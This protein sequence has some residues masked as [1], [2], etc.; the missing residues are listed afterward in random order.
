[1]AKIRV[2]LV[3][4]HAV[5]RAGVRML[6]N[7]Q[8]D[9]EVCGEAA[10]AVEAIT[11]TE[12]TQPDVVT[13]DL[14]MPGGSGLKMIE[15]LRLAGPKSRILVLTMHDDPAY[16][17]AA[18]AAGCTGYVVKTAADAALLTAIRAV[19]RGRT[20]VDMALTEGGLL[21]A[22][23]KPG[24][25]GSTLSEREREVFQLLVQGHTNQA[26]ADKLNLSVKTVETYRARIGDKLGLKSRADMVRYAMETGMLDQPG[27]SGT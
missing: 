12:E 23:T 17:R 10:S 1:M 9:M 18:L 19:H 4:D 3:D 6:I 27:E 22:P 13:L 20:F 21:A 14:S 11:R 26:I 25:A 24:P 5:L 7:A 2:L 16:L 8:S 15:K